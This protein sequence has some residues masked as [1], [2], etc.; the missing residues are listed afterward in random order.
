M[1]ITFRN[2]ASAGVDGTTLTITKPSGV[3]DNDIL[4]AAII[5]DGG[6]GCTI[7]PPDGT[8]NSE[9]RMNSGTD[10][11]LEVFTKKA[12]S[13]GASYDFGISP[14]GKA[15]GGICAYSGCDTTTWVDVENGQATS[16]GTNHAAPSITPTVANTMLVASYGLAYKSSFTKDASMDNEQ[17]DLDNGAGG[18]SARRT[19]CQDDE[20]YAPASATGTRT[21]VS[22]DSAVGCA[23]MLALRPGSDVQVIWIQDEIA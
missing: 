4:V 10:V 17:W 5:V 3:V 1:A 16:S 11:G 14:T 22:A 15:V 7:T 12:S 13:E 6:T 19:G 18:P 20:A 9:R 8:W 2:V 23:H 21:A